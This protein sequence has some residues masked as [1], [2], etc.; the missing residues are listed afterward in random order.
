MARKEKIE[1][2]NIRI[3]EHQSIEDLTGGRI[4]RLPEGRHAAPGVPAGPVEGPP[5]RMPSVV[6]EER[7]SREE[8]MDKAVE[9]SD[10][11]FTKAH[12]GRHPEL[13]P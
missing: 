11:S 1:N 7:I 12:E 10:Q 2:P 9:V 3:G 4:R 8:A 6:G 5:P 13:E